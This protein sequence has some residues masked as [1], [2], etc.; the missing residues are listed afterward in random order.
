MRNVTDK[1]RRESKNTHFMRH[2]EKYDEAEQYTDDNA[3][4]GIH[5]SRRI[6]KA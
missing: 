4:R 1:S 2:C 6:T 3:I 5:F